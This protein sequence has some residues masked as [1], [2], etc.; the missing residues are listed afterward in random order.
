MRKPIFA[1]VSL[2]AMALAGHAQAQQVPDIYLGVSA[3]TYMPTNSTIRRAFGDNVFNY[4]ISPMGAQ[5]ASGSSAPSIEFQ[6]ANNNGNRLFIGSLT[7]GYQK[8]FGDT[9]AVVVP[10][11]RVFVGGTY[12]DY[13]IDQPGGRQSGKKFGTTGGA[14]LGIVISNRLRLSAK[15][16]FYS[17]VDGFDFQGLTLSATVS[18]FKL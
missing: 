12:F 18:L 2:A 11:G 16:N 14:E 10:Y 15:Y 13:G 4:G 9:S 1:L 17:K 3:G 8:L 7:Y 5:A 6:S